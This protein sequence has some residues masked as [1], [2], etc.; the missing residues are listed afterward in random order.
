ML[1][2]HAN[3]YVERPL[4]SN[5][6]CMKY[7]MKFLLINPNKSFLV[8]TRQAWRFKSAIMFLFISLL[9]LVSMFWCRSSPDNI[10]LYCAN[11]FMFSGLISMCFFWSIK[12][13]S[14]KK[15]L[16]YHIIKT[17]DVND[18]FNVIMTF[19]HCPVCNYS[20]EQSTEPSA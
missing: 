10:F 3:H 13:P 16:G 4:T 6:L 15:W 5:V 20:G 12:C 17:S 18:W 9:L 8:K 19:E 2:Q 1:F 11:G 7:M 14:C